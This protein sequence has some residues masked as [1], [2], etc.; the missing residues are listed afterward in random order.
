VQLAA[1]ATGLT[2][3]RGYDIKCIGSHSIRASGAMSLKRNGVDDTLI[4]LL[5]RWSSDT[6]KKHIRP[7]ISNLTEGLAEIMSVL[8]FHYTG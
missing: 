3:D 2:P 6:F 5:G 7:Q 8:A 1:V 4:Q